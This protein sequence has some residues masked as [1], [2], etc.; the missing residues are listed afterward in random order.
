ML[1]KNRQNNTSGQSLTGGLPARSLGMLTYCQNNGWQPLPK[2]GDGDGSNAFNHPL[3]LSDRGCHPAGAGVTAKHARLRYLRRLATVMSAV[4]VFCMVGCQNN[5]SGQPT[6]I[7][8]SNGQTYVPGRIPDRLPQSTRH[9]W[10]PPAYEEKLNQWEG[11]IIHHTVT[12]HGPASFIDRLHKDKGYDE[13]GYHFVINNGRGQKDG[14]VEPT[15][16]WYKQKH[17]AHCRVNKN[18]NNYWNQ[19]TIGIGLIG[20]FEK[21]WPT[22]AQYDSLARLV[23]FLQKRYNISTGEVKGHKHIKP[24]K[25]PGKNFS[26]T[27]LKRRIAAIR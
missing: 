12:D 10:L 6:V 9:P 14:K 21:T 5:R 18:D 19:H 4:V 25:C 16:R 8:T 20:N 23:R 7:R 13:L 2:A 17:G 1:K 15:P 22:N 27:E 24:T 3:S 26:F 11:I